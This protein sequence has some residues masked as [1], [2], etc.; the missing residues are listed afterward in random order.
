MWRSLESDAFL[1]REPAL[2]GALAVLGDDP[3]LAIGKAEA[4]SP[5]GPHA[6]CKRHRMA[7][8]IEHQRVAPLEHRLGRHGF[9]ACSDAVQPGACLPQRT[10]Q[11]CAGKAC[12]R[13]AG[14]PPRIRKGVA[15]SARQMSRGETQRSLAASNDSLRRPGDGPDAPSPTAAWPA[16]WAMRRPAAERDLPN[17]D[18][19]PRASRANPEWRVR[20]A[21]GPPSGPR[22]GSATLARDAPPCRPGAGAH[23]R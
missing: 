13:S 10:T 12:K 14:A 1:Q 15:Q 18:A 2:A 20:R 23:H 21:T 3:R 22:A 6:R 17:A 5:A 8:G 19:P 11:G 9:E 7:G 16:N 4:Q